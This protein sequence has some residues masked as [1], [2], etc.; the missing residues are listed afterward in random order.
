MTTS[1]DGGGASS[2]ST[3]PAPTQVAQPTDPWT[4][5]VQRVANGALDV[6]RLDQTQDPDRDRIAAL[7]ETAVALCDSYLDRPTTFTVASV[8]APVVQAAVTVTVE[9]YKRK[10]APF[11]ITG[12]WSPEGGSMRISRD[13]LAG[14]ETLL[15]PYRGGWGVA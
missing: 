14:V 10:D 7:A 2:P 11:G 8:P 1:V 9:L 12:A 5:D 6:Q 4:A 13:I 3:G 15:A